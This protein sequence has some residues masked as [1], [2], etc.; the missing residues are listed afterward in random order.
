M[1]TRIS[2]HPLVVTLI[3]LFVTLLGS[4]CG[5][6][7]LES[8][9]STATATDTTQRAQSLTGALDDNVVV[10]G[11]KVYTRQRNT[12][13]LYT[14]DTPTRTWQKVGGP[15]RQFVGSGSALYMLTLDGQAVWQNK[16]GV[17]T[18]IGG[19]AATLYAGA[20]G[21]LSTT[22]TNGDVFYFNEANNSWVK[23]GAAGSSFA[24]GQGVIY[25]ISLDHDKLYRQFLSTPGVWSEIGGATYWVYPGTARMYAASNGSGG[26]TGDVWQ[27]M[28]NAW[29]WTG[30]PGRT[31]AVAGDTLFGLGEDGMVYINR[32]GTTWS[33]AGGP[34]QWIYGGTGNLMCAKIN[35]YFGVACYD[36][37]TGQW[38][39]LGQP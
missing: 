37:S 34:V 1:A 19:P 18:Q 9:P 13:D 12:G 24:M 20:S 8:T 22:T 11:T 33:L 7:Q 27:F 30:G 17:W 4:A 5:D 29:S 6:A 16:N 35:T 14:Y 3:G 38:T 28:G 26:M 31:F 10:V 32:D 36:V 39:T 23:V 25:G 21:L 2:R 15:A